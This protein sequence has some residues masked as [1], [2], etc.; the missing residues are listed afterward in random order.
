MVGVSRVARVRV[1]VALLCVL[2]GV[3]ITAGPTPVAHAASRAGLVAVPR[4][5]V[6][7]PLEGGIRGRPFMGLLSVPK[8]FLEEEYLVSG[9]ARPY[10]GPLV[11]AQQHLPVTSQL[12]AVPYTTRIIVVRPTSPQ[13][14]NHTAVVTWENV[15]FGHDI[16]EWFDIGRQVVADGYTY[17][18]A[19]VQLASEPG[20][21]VF[22]PV[23]YATVSI[24]I[25]AY[26]YDIYSQVAQAL[27]HPSAI[28]GTPLRHVLALGA[29]QS[30][31]ALDQYLADVQ[32]VQERVYDGFIVAVA[33]GPDHHTDR[34]VIRLLSEDEIDGSS[35]SPDVKLYRQWEVAG[36]AHGNKA[37]FDY[38]SAQERRDLGV[39]LVNP[40]AGDNAPFGLSTCQMNRFPADQGYAAALVALR[41]WVV[42]G[43]APTSQPR[44]KVVGGAIRRDKVGNAIG[45]IRLPAMAVPTAAYNRTGDCVALDG[46]TEAFTPSQLRKLYPTH[47]VYV[48]KV[49]RAAH[50]SLHDGVLTRPDMR[51]VIAQ[52]RAAR[53]PA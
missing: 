24:P 38:I 52:A 7:G 51:L 23:R 33:N 3:L 28:H 21:K 25:D 27:R 36:S 41:R 47:K 29:S 12:P 37:D 17:V 46:R 39:D 1:L 31:F 34:P 20:L 16:D 8:G 4:P 30:G 11:L 5:T 53:V 42:Q 44:V 9:T 2:S 22:D 32:P 43:T 10:Y 19:S 49:T 15:T 26:S 35:K 6:T 45:G 48:A 14:S 40:L 50:R 13:R 18:D